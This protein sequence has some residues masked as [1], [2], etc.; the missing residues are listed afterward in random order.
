[1]NWLQKF[2]DTQDDWGGEISSELDGGSFLESLIQSQGGLAYLRYVR[3]NG[4]YRFGDASSAYGLDHKA[5]AGNDDVESA[6]FVKV[7]SDGIEIEGH[8]MTLEIGPDAQDYEKL[9]LLFG[10]P[11]LDKYR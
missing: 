6:A 5:L 8:S 7:L 1:M 11:L 2:A 9:P 4:K 3:I 10:K